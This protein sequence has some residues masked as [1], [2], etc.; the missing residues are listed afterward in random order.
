MRGVRDSYKADGHRKG[1][2]LKELEGNFSTEH[3][4][5]LFV[6]DLDG[7]LLTNQREIAAVDLK[8]LSRLRQMGFLTA[9]ATG[10]SNY[11]FN[12]LMDAL[13]YSGPKSSLPVDYII[14]STGAG[15]M[16][17]PGTKLLKCFSLSPENVQTIVAYLGT[18]DLDFMVHKPVPDTRHFLY[19]YRSKN[20]PDFEERLKMYGDFATQLLPGTLDNFGGATEVLCI[21]SQEKGHETA[22]QL[23]NFFNRFS[24]IKATSPLDGK[25]IWV[26]IFSPE[27]SKS[28]AV[29]WLA[30]SVCIPRK[31]ICAVGNDYNDRDLL[32][33][34]EK[35]FVVANGPPSL[36]SIF[37][38]VGSN[39]NGGVSEAVD[40][41]LKECFSLKGI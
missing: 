3:Y 33:W 6:T 40:I 31:N 35:G 22:A 1:V 38:T 5:G 15:I 11:S 14:F 34:A 2:H 21:V 37:E 36:K 9:I 23:A 12:R 20:N 8:A 18:S 13:G 29:M 32:H 19:S 30:D 7:T 16:N 24:V 4:K 26:E 41:W 27:V 39:D 17:F 10:R 25:S 28:Q